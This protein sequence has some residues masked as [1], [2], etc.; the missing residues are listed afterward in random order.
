M[1]IL[2]GSKYII[3]YNKDNSN[4][5]RSTLDINIYLTKED[6]HMINMCI[7]RCSSYVIREMKI[8]TMRYHS[9][10]I[11]MAKIQNTVKCW[12]G[13]GATGALIHCCLE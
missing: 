2:A 11:R 7:K 10:P 6:I 3:N 13:H 1:D 9:T 12:Q 8:K 4:Y 5:N